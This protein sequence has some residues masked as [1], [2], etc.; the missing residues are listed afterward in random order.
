MQLLFLCL[1]VFFVRIIDVSLGTF[2]TV[3]TVKG[4]IKSASVIGFFEVLIWFLIVKE[5]LN[6]SENSIFIGISY[7]LGFATGTYIG[8]IISFYFVDGIVTM[9]IISS[10]LD[11]S[12]KLRQNGYAVTEIEVRGK[13]ASEKRM[14]FLQIHAK[15]NDKLKKLIAQMDPKA[16]IVVQES[17]QVLNGYFVSN[18]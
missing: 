7:A 1:K 14:L 12:K 6:T 8:G 2:R 15:E 10:Q 3:V 5:A 9:E 4:K 17:Q 16:F 13:D 11:L 18:K